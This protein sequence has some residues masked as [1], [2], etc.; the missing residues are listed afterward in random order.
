[1]DLTA[2][3]NDLVNAFVKGF[4]LSGFLCVTYFIGFGVKNAF[5][6]FKKIVK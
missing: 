3:T 4:S 1:M 5:S 2:M 6:F